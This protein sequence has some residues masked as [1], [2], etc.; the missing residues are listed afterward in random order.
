MKKNIKLSTKEMCEC[1]LFAVL[2][3]IGAF[4][5]IPVSI[6]PITLQTLF[7]VMAAMILGPRKAVTSVL[8][9]I[10]I[11]L[12]GIPVFANG[13]G[14]AYVLQP[15]FGYLLGFVLAAWFIGS[16]TKLKIG[17][18]KSLLISV[19]GMLIIYLLGMIYFY[20]IERYVYNITYGW[21][22]MIYFLFIVYLPGDMLSCFVA[23]YLSRK[24]NRLGIIEK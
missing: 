4:I 24:I 9:Y 13:G 17:F 15:S 10:I 18:W 16:L 21:Q 2:I 19:A 7:V 3:A 6:V 23:T 14:L 5:K 11:G 8:L 12:L 1:S 22:W 20:L